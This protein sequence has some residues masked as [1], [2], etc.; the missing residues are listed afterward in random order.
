MA[1]KYPPP[2]DGYRVKCSPYRTLPDGTRVYASQYG[3][4][5]FCWL[6]S[7]EPDKK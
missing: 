7:I 2:P 6:E 3:K 4:K 1:S 5:V